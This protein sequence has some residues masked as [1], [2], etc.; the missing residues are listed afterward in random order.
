MTRYISLIQATFGAD[1]D[2][3]HGYPGHEELELA[4]MRLF[5]LTN[6]GE[7]FDLARYFIEERGQRRDGVHYYEMEAKLN[8]VTLFPGHFKESG[9]FEYMQAGQP[10]RQ[11]PTIEGVLPR[12]QG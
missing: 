7:Y 10:I 3:L 2:K 12:I 8:G 9:W 6:A 11:Q 5:H 1:K 4:L